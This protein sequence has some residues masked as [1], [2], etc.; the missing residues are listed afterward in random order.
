MPGEGKSYII[1]NRIYV[2]WGGYSQLKCLESLYDYALNNYR[3]YDRIFLLSCLDYIIY[4]RIEFLNYCEDNADKEFIR[5]YNI[6]K[7][8]RKNQLE[9]IMLY[10]LFRDI[11]LPHKSFIRRALI[12]GS[13]YFLKAIGVRRKPYLLVNGKNGMFIQVHNGQV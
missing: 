13:K 7:G 1:D 9:R 8:E 5:V 12:G 11:H 2:T 4:S 10:H 3:N 6:T